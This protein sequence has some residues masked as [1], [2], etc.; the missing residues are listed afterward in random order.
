MKKLFYLSMTVLILFSSMGFTIATHYC[1]GYEVTSRFMLGEGELSCG[2]SGIESNFTQ[3]GNLESLNR[4]SCC[5]NQYLSLCI[6]ND[7]NN[8]LAHSIVNLSVVQYIGIVHSTIKISNLIQDI[9]Y[10]SHSPPYL[11]PDMQ[12]LFQTFLN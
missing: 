5:E 11:T 7:Y 2:M 4:N 1:G 12:V 3:Y 10:L 6:E 8:T 9:P